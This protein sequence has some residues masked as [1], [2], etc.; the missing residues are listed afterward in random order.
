MPARFKDC[1]DNFSD[2]NGRKS[3]IGSL[4]RL[5]PSDDF[6]GSKITYRIS[7]IEVSMTKMK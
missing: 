3:L 4:K 6:G 5:I 2:L 1:L 7:V